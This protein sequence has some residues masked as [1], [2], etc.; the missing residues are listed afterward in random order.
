LA[1][2]YIHIPFCKQACHYCDFHFS[3]Q[4]G[5]KGRLLAAMHQEIVLQKEYLSG[6]PLQTIYLGGGTPSLLEIQEIKPLL[7]SIG[8]YHT[9]NSDAEITLEANP[10]DL[11]AAYLHGLKSVGIN[12]LSIGIQSFQEEVLTFLNRAHTTEQAQEA[13]KLARAAGFNN[14]SIDLIYGIPGTSHQDWRANLTKAISLKTEHIS[15]YALTIEEKTAFGHWHKK[16][17]LVPVAE[18]FAA[19]Q[20][21]ILVDTLEMAGYEQYEISNFCLPGWHS[22]HNSAYWRGTKYLGIGPAAHSYK[23]NC[24]QFNVSN[25]IKYVKSLEAGLVPFEE[26]PLSRQDQI[27]EYLLTSL[28]TSIGCDLHHLMK[29]W[30]VD[31][32]QSHKSYLQSLF[33]EGH[34]QVVDHHLVLTRSGKLLADRIS[35]DLFIMDT[36]N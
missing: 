31:L 4:L 25:N 22:R 20:F 16:G 23:D 3:T 21:E 1:G 32:L 12:R 15:A 9:I 14:I 34:A 28:R 13:V 11:T 35:S 8:S 33:I 19:E 2:I 27:N 7:D 24:R 18:E 10:D 5:G 30:G 26:D 6:A 17:R 29:E 36:E